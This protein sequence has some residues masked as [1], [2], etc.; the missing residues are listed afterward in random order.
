MNKKD[1][2]KSNLD[3]FK[4]EDNNTLL[5]MLQQMYL[6]R[7]FENMLLRLQKEN[8]IHGP[9]HTSIGQE[10]VGV[11][12]MNAIRSTDF[13]LGTH[14][15][16]HEFLAKALSFH[17]PKNYTPLEQEFS[18]QMQ[19]SVNNLLAEI[20]G[21]AP[22]YCGGRGG[23]MHL[24]YPQVG[25]VGTNAIVAGGIPIATG[26]AFSQ[27][28]LK[29]DNIVVSFMG[30][31][32][33]NQGSFHEALNLAGLWKL[34]II[35]IIENNLYSVATRV[36]ETVP[37][38][39][40]S[41]RAS[42]YG[43]NSRVVDGNDPIAIKYI[44]EKAAEEIRNMGSPYLI[45]ALTYRFL[46][47]GGGIQGSAYGYR[48]QDEED[49]WIKKDPLITF[50]KKL[51]QEDIITKNDN[52]KI[53]KIV[54]SV[55]KNAEDYCFSKDPFTGKVSIRDSLW[56]KTENLKIGVRSNEKEFGNVEFV[57]AQDLTLDKE[58]KYIEAIAAVTGRWLQNDKGVFVIGEEVGH[59]KGGVYMATAGLPQR[60][61]ERLIN[62][63]ISEA[64]FTGLS[65]GAAIVGLKP[66]IEIMFPDFVLV[67]ADQ[68]FNQIGKLRYI[69]GGNLSIPIVMRT[70]VSKG[71]GY[72]GQHSMDPVGLFALFPGWRIVAPS[73]PFDY[74]GLFNTAM[75]SQ[76]PVLI[77]EHYMLYNTTG[78]ISTDNLDYFIKMGRSKKVREGEDLTV[79]CYSYMVPILK[80]VASELYKIDKVNVEVIDLR[81]LDLANI[82]YK[83]IGQ[84]LKKTGRIAIVEQASKSMS[85]GSHIA[86]KCMDLFFDYLDA[87]VLCINSVDVPLPV[88]RVLESATLPS[89]DS[90]TNDLREF[91]RG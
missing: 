50:Q 65:F 55:I 17:A 29:K 91:L 8:L 48:T 14:R 20:I 78:L 90:I 38:K 23:S 42:S 3:I 68:I 47:H 67:A 46:H 15:A 41:T 62:A 18:P 36:E 43:I 52:E 51:F 4:K 16:H 87:P 7:E 83:M 21:L 35:Y 30:E 22:G 59:F 27:K 49:K 26:V 72:G 84:S 82:D 60:Y 28:Y 6:I 71:R 32:A 66:I 12:S 31:G 37:I 74:I 40:V 45:E 9:I 54:N 81:T 33:I 56:P 5:F 85:L 77:V 75:L 2:F 88:S 25:V 69:Y 61:P 34:P 89:I 13:M 53:M 58:V 73:T 76:D 80:K 79:L 39:R 63:P 1:I 70:Q 10:A 24:S 19:D 64:G 44:V 57:E 11:G 86:H